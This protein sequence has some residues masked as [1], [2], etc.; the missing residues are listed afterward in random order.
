MSRQRRAGFFH[1][2]TRQ[3]TFALVLMFVAGAGV[4]GFT[5]YELNLRTHD[6]V[7]LNLAGQL[8][9]LA[10]AMVTESLHFREYRTE[11]P[12][13]QAAALFLANI[14][15]QADTFDRI[16][17][18]LQ[19]RLLP[20][21]LTGRNDPL[22]CSWDAQSIGQLN[23][24]AQTWQ[25]F[26]V[27]IAPIF[28]PKPGAEQLEHAADY[29]IA[30]ERWLNVVAQ[31]L[32]NA[33]QHM[34]ERKMHLIVLFNQGALALFFVAV[35]MLLSLL[36]LTFV[37]PLRTTVDGI[38]RITQGEFG[39]QIPVSTRN[40]IGLVAD[41]FNGMSL[42]LGSLFRLTDRINQATNVDTMLRFVFE[43]FR[44]FIPLDWLGLLVFDEQREHFLLQRVVS[45]ISTGLHE[46]D[47]FVASGSMLAMALS[48]ARPLHVPDLVTLARENPQAQFA[49]QLAQD[50]RRSALFY[51]LGSAGEWGAIL[52]FAVDREAAYNRDH[53]EFLHNIAAQIGHG[54]EKTVVTE[55]LVVSAVT[56]LAKLA[57]NR[58]PET[59]DHLVR[60]ALYSAI[61]AEELG[62]EDAFSERID[63]DYVRDIQRFAPMHDIGKVG[64]ADHILLKPGRLD[65]DE[66][67]E[68]ERHPAIGGE[69][70]R[71]CE[72]QM[73]EVGH[74][75][76]WMGIEIAEAHHEKFDGSGY[77]HGLS[78]E[79]I[80]LS[81]RIVAVA[82]VFDALTSRRPYKEAWSVERALE[83]IVSESGGHFD[84]AIVAALQRGLPRV[85]D[86][87]DRLRHV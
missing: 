20:P 3:I 17:T 39:H 84:P 30:N 31:N 83:Y 2:L 64:V 44:S 79:N 41:A 76:F 81:A 29:L 65:A 12:G 22:V 42:R 61:V 21:E 27:G 19:N 52:A 66:R 53:L 71:R 68:M 78:G 28:A 87:Y 49:E 45:D 14:R 24:T 58:D 63:A 34:M 18:S 82:D 25:E 85:L 55:S 72:M 77:P 47:S 50:G 62:T 10:Q 1:S 4:V 51:P 33:F 23:L 40:E 6:Y 9:A 57:E 36:Y 35:V 75:V 54:F 8:R 16:V 37:K 86:V 73:N 32:S 59:G 26:R 67:R 74:S 69:V 7:I 11:M 80:P 15:V 5:V 43:E 38:G 60:M 13:D 48:E 70:L 46:G 56:G